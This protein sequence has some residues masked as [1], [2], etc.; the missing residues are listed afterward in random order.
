[1]GMLDVARVFYLEE[2]NCFHCQPWVSL[3]G[4]GALEDPLRSP[5]LWGGPIFTHWMSVPAKTVVAP[6]IPRR[7]PFWAFSVVLSSGSKGLDSS[8]TRARDRT[9][10]TYLAKV[11]RRLGNQQFSF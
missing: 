6:A 11:S 8:P 9:C 7:P 5:R 10:P 4:G 1:M 3:G 2:H